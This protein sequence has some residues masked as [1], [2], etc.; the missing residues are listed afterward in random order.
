[1]VAPVKTTAWGGLHGSLA[2]ILDDTDYATVT[3]NIVT[4]LA[5][6]SKLTT[7]NPKINELS[8][9]YAILT[10][11]EEMKT[12]PKEF[13]LQEAV[14]T[15]RVQRI[16][17][18]IKEQYVKELNKD[19]FGY[20]NQ[21][22]KRLLT[23]L[24]TNWCKVITKERTNA[25]EAFYQAWLPLTTHIITFG[26]QL[27][28]QQKKCKNI[29]VIISEEA[30]TLHFVGQMYKS[31]YYTKEQMTKYKMQADVNKTWFHTLQ[32]FTK[33]FAQRKAYGD[34]DAANSGFDSAAH[35]NNIPTNCSLVSTSSDFT[36]RNLYIESL[37]ELLAAAREYVSKECAPTPDKPD[38]VDLLRMELE[39]QCKQFG[40]IMKQNSTLLAAMAKGNGGGGSGGGGGGGGGGSGGGSGGGGGNKHR[41]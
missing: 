13:E 30:K 21:T 36:T 6:L 4:L 11:Q 18:S 1:M 3:K 14:T 15:I 17:D 33:P 35:I 39:A 16:I 32:F 41:N 20:A 7:I 40:L 26:R 27:N 10:L 34:S 22:I 8:N 24:H 37:G 31:N 25:T 2:L 23:H 5:P 29:N 19:Y 12:L 38:P 28:K 9:P